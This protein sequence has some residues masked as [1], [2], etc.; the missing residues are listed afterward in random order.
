MSRFTIQIT[1]LIRPDDVLNEADFLVPTQFADVGVHHILNGFKTAEVTL[2]MEDPVVE[3]LEPRE[4]ALRILYENRLEPVFWGPCN[5][6]DDYENGK[7]ILNAQD[8]SFRLL[9]HYLRRGD[10]A[11]NGTPAVDKGTITPDARGII[12]VIAA[13][14][15]YG[16]QI[17]RNDPSLGVFV[18]LSGSKYSTERDLP[19]IV[20]RGQ[21][22]WQV[23]T[24]IS[25]HDV[26]PD[27]DMETPFDGSLYFYT[28]LA[29]YDDLGRDLT[30]DITWNYGPQLPG[31]NIEPGRATTHAHVLSRDAKFRRTAGSVNASNKVGPHVDWIPTDLEF[32]DGDDAALQ[33]KANDVVKA[34]AYAPKF[35]S[36]RQRPDAVLVDNYGNPS[37]IAPGGTKPSTYYIGDRITVA[38]TRGYRSFNGPARIIEVHLKQSGPRG[39]VT[40][41]LKLVPTVGDF[42]DDEEA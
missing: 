11:I 34:Y 1:P 35:L 32:P 23:I 15:N 26:G 17:T 14:D 28:N 5:I 12:E 8:P 20:E 37:F 21:E 27:I 31:V 25:K 41:E 7:C 39:L 16:D 18:Y 3:G 38:A 22:C 24:N 19:I 9:H 2:S 4:F 29:T 33:A 13:A 10:D 6:N 30:A 40:T 42:G 36:I